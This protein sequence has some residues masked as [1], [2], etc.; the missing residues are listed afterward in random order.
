MTT[1]GL[2]ALAL[3]LALIANTGTAADPK[4]PEAKAF[5]KAVIDSLRAVHNKG[6]DL[7]NAAK[8]YPGAYRLYQGALESVRPLLAHRP[9]VQKIIDGG[10]AAAEK[11][12]DAD[13]KAFR[14]H[15]T[16]EEVR[17]S[18]K[19]A[20]GVQKPEEK[21]P[22]EKKLVEK[23]PEE[24]KPEEKKP[25]EKKPEEKPKDKADVS[26]MPKAKVGTAKVSG[27]V[28]VA[29]KPLAAGDVTIVSLNLAAP[30]VFSAEVVKGDFTFAEPVPSGKY[31]A[32]VTGAGVPAQYHLVTSSGLMFEFATGPIQ[33]DIILK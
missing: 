24:K 19:A 30:R 10:L 16:I 33:A 21:K 26:P 12:A 2:A 8:D 15:E 23:K 11:E 6:A 20:I 32:I 27:K 18:L 9:E 17:N 28:T 31:T 4:L 14:L 22:E 25:V 1:K 29:G 3:A 7:Y 13:R 5:D